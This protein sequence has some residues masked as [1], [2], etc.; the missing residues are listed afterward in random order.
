EC[1]I[2]ECKVLTSK[3][4][5]VMKK[6]KRIG[7]K[8]D[9]YGLEWNFDIGE[10]KIQEVGV[11]DFTV[12]PE[13]Y[14][15]KTPVE[16]TSFSF[17]M[18]ELKLGDWTPVAVIEHDVINGNKEDNIIHVINN[19]VEIPVKYRTVDS[20]CDHCNTN[21][22]R[23][24]TILLIDTAGEFKQVGTTCVDEFTGIDAEKIIGYYEEVGDIFIEDNMKINFS[25]FAPKYVKT[26]DYLTACIT[27]II[28]DGYK[29]SD[30]YNPTSRIAFDMA[31]DNNFDER[32]RSK[33]EEVIEFFANFEADNTFMHDIKT[34]IKREYTTGNGYLAY[35]Y[36]AYKKE[37][38]RQEELNGFEWV[39]KVGDRNTWTVKFDKKF[40]FDTQWGTQT[41]Y[42]FNDES[43][44]IFKWKTSTFSQELYEALNN[45]QLKGID[46]KIELT[47]T[48]KGHEE[49]K[50]KKQTVL[51]R[52]KLK[53]KEVK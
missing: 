25:G 17:E 14:K 48:I 38:E 36:L 40:S 23:N 1:F 4:D 39:G 53:I 12:Y 28:A 32:Y 52:C 2:M 16:V 42:L 18:E 8:L 51:S 3:F 37:L 19:D 46:F 13:Q 21:R 27:S 35:A 20:N 44:N 47:G 22:R 11:W 49:Y 15:G 50:G 34:Y 24:K 6:I 29:K 5:S 33:A 9:K 7:K 31:I 45:K 26:I 41:I 30:T 43:G 10:T